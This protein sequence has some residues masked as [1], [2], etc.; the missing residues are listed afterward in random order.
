M[1]EGIRLSL[2]IRAGG[3]DAEVALE[4]AHHERLFRTSCFRA[5]RDR[6]LRPGEEVWA[7][8]VAGAVHGTHGEVLC[9]GSCGVEL[10][11]ADGGLVT[12]VDF[13]RNAFAAFAAARAVHRLDE[14][15]LPLDSPIRFSL[16]GEPDGLGALPTAL[17]ALPRMAVSEVLCGSVAWATPAAA[18][19]VTAIG[20]HVV[21]GFDELENL[22][23]RMR[24]EAAGRI[25]GR[26]GFD[27][28]RGVFVRT[29]DRLLVTRSTEASATTVVSTPQSWAEV[30]AADAP[31]V[32][33]YSSVHTHLHLDEDGDLG[34]AHAPC[35]SIQDLVTHYVTFPD[36]LSAMLILSLFP[37]DRRVVALYGYAPDATLRA[38]RGW[39]LLPEE[40]IHAHEGC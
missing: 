11:R 33:V 12:T 35:V 5:I 2:S 14:A 26:V 24:Q 29:L 25:L 30:P 28:E 4:P 13:G 16:H 10:R 40:P 27:P 18:W 7:R 8:I 9:M 21:A 32:R 38:E 1:P 17:P 37:G 15:G 34:A 3:L 31:G 6:L 23:R 36:P 19:V 22:S 20:P 39:W